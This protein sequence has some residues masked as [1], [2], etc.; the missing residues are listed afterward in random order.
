[1]HAAL[2][3]LLLTLAADVGDDMNGGA[4]VSVTGFVS[5]RAQLTVP[6]LSSPLSTRDLPQLQSLTEAS[7]LLKL[8]LLDDRLTFVVDGSAFVTLQGLYADAVDGDHFEV[9][10][11]HDV[12]ADPRVVFAE[13]YARLQPFEHLDISVGKRRVVWG[14]GMSFNPTDIL[15]PPRDPTDGALQRTGIPMVLVETPFDGLTLSTFFAPAILE[16]KAGIP[17]ALLMW[18]DVAPRESLQDPATFPDPRDDR[19]HWAGAVR[20]SALVLETD[21]N[22]WALVVNEY[23][24]DTRENSP[25]LALSLSRIFFE[26]HEVH[27]ELLVQQ[28]SDK[29]RVNGDCVDDDVVDVGP[30]PTPRLMG[31]ALAGEKPLDRDRLDDDALY[32]RLLVGTRSMFGD[33]TTVTFEYLY[34]ADGFTQEEWDH[35][36]TLQTRIGGLTRDGLMDPAAFLSTGTDASGQPARLA[37]APQR[38]HHLVVNYSRPQ[39]FDDFTVN[40]TGIIALEDLSSILTGSVQWQ[41]TEWLQLSLWAF[42]PTPSLPRALHALG[43]D[44]TADVLWPAVV[45]GGPLGEYD[46]LPFSARGLLEA[47]VWF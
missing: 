7:A 14:T 21:I 16:E 8:R 26:I 39:I 40:A 19:A 12:P 32:P 41:A 1:M 15:N 46:A 27:G 30:L 44:G 34:Q 38:Q 4:E 36:A 22:V 42:V 45:D 2:P 18:P 17:S 35:M 20:A 28:G 3:L 37:V 5:E 6:S 31:C 23:G 43:V 33:G 13:A 9:V 10:A 24:L 29:V 47:R 11:D 25:R